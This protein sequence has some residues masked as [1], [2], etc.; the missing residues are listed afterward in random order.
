MPTR[1]DD[2][3]ED[4]SA[5]VEELPDAG[6]LWSAGRRRRRWQQAGAA[7]GAVVLIAGIGGLAATLDPFGA[8]QIESV[9]GP[10]E[11][12]AGDPLD[13]GDEDPAGES[14]RP[15]DRDPA[16]G[17][18]EVADQDAEAEDPDPGPEPD[19]E[20]VA[21]PCAPH[22]DAEG[23]AFIDLVAPVDGQ[24]V[25]SE[26]ELV[27]C[28]S[29][30]EATVRY[31]LL[32]AGGEVLADSFTTATAGGPE[33]G[34]FRDTVAVEASGELTLEVFWDSPADGSEA[35]KTTVALRAE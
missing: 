21:D 5:P 3:L 9:A 24:V 22:R 25:A 26:V 6:R 27:G 15:A 30:Y 13:G 14:S 28:A 17:E 23:E 29:V 20:A 7:M 19:A 8:P 1:L 35:D 32:D 12:D 11:A 33:I 18:G 10:G 16:D 31:R 2:L 4:A 34:E